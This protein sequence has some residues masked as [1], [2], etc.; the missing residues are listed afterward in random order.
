MNLG[1]RLKQE[2]QRLR[3]TQA[4]LAAIGGVEPNALMHYEHGS[5][6]PRAD[7]LA[8][9]DMIGVDLLYVITGTTI[10]ES[11]PDLVEA[12]KDLVLNLRALP[13]EDQ[14]SI[15]RIIRSLAENPLMYMENQTID[16]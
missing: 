11:S 14:S 5:R 4:E 8:A 10:P 2:R 16:G 7:F 12:E 13:R 6:Q 3:L 9:L 1:N 15:T